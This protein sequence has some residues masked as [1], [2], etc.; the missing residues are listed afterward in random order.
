[1]NIF[2]I[3]TEKL[4]R[5]VLLSKFVHSLKLMDIVVIYNVTLAKNI[6]DYLDKLEIPYYPIGELELK[7]NYN[8]CVLYNLPN[9]IDFQKEVEI[10]NLI[11]LSEKYE[12]PKFLSEKY[13]S[14]KENVNSFERKSINEYY[15]REG[16]EFKSVNGDQLNKFL[17]REIKLS[18]ILE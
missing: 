1:M 7:D 2:S 5:R 11:I 16:R 12:S 6:K 9:L 17:I 18:T 15:I 14:D 10:K 13:N 3:H 8:V 4:E